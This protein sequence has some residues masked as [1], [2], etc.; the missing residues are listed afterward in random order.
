MDKDKDKDKENLSFLPEDYVEKQI[1]K[2]TNL[3]CLT[4]FV[5]VLLG[6]IGAYVVTSQKNTNELKTQKDIN[7]R[8]TEAA[9]RISQL[10]ELQDQKA[11]LLRKAQ[12]TATLIEP[13]P[14]S[15]LLA[16][17][18][19][20]MPDT[21]SLTEMTLTSKKIAPPKPV[22]DKKKSALSNK[23]KQEKNTT[24]EPA[25]P[26]YDVKIQLIGVAPT[27]IQVAQYMSSLS[28]SPIVTDIDLVYSEERRI[29][30]ATMRRFK[31]IMR[32]D[33]S[34]DIRRIDPLIVQR[35]LNRPMMSTNPFFDLQHQLSDVFN[36]D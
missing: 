14:R 6:I 33:P 10:N 31:M 23:K 34:A 28:R 19:N 8:Y 35:K 13:V 21:L 36:E 15:N 20:R 32:I 16:D 26:E 29:A 27:D 24:T 25:G 17:L 9:R 18:I 2:R 1:E 7:L 30:D 12:I 4:L 3:I 22:V 11:L 5:I